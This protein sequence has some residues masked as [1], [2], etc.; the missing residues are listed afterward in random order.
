MN[1]QTHDCQCAVCPGAACQCGCQQAAAN[2]GAAL[3]QACPCGP[4]CQ[5]G[6]GCQCAAA[7]CGCLCAA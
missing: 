6:P 5:C 2:A 3:Q 7:E 4:A 1:Q